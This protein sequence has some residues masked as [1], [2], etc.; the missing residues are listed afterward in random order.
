MVAD[1]SKDATEEELP[2]PPR[3]PPLD[4]TGSD[5]HGGERENNRDAKYKTV[6]NNKNEYVLEEGEIPGDREEQ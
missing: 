5:S 6:Y 4:D 2:S 1:L 3:N